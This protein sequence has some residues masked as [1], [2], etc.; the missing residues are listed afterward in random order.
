MSIFF[1]II[2]MILGYKE[3]RFPHPLKSIHKY[4]RAKSAYSALSLGLGF[5][6]LVAPTEQR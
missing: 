1:Y 6:Y 4:K 2:D 5:V 3:N